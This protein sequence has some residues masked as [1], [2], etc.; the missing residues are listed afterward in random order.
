[1]T[2]QVETLRPLR[3]DRVSVYTCGLTV[4]QP[5]AY[6]QLD[7]LYLL[8]YFGSYTRAEGYSVERTQNI[9][10]VGHLVS[11]DDAGEDKMEKGARAEGITAWDVAQKYSA[12][13]EHE[14]YDMLGLIRP[15]HL[16]TATSCVDTQIAF[17]KVLDDKRLLVPH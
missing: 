5:A 17:V 6:W 1:M 2:G 13:A 8:G 15:D 10:D 3:A 12:I 16:V 14:G 9:T 11:D 4:C 7:R